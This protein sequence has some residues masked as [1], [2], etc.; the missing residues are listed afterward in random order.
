MN[1]YGTLLR[2]ALVADT[3]WTYADGGFRLPDRPGLGVEIDE[4]AVA[5]YTAST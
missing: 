3:A 1:R 2:A 5:R 4:E